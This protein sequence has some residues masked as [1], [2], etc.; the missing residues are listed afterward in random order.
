MSPVEDKL[1][2]AFQEKAGDIPACAPPLRLPARPRRS[3]FLAHGGGEKKGMPGYRAWHRWTAPVASA[4]LVVAV[5][6][7]SAVV[8]RDGSSAVFRHG[9]PSSPAHATATRPLLVAR[10]SSYLGVYLGMSPTG[11]PS[12]Q[13]A[14]SFAAAARTGPNLVE[15]VSNWGQPFA[16]SYAQTLRK[17]GA[18]MVVQLDPTDASLA[19]IPAGRY[20]GYLSSYAESVRD[21]GHPVII[22]FAHEMNADWWSWGYMHSRPSAAVA[23]W[24]HIVNLFR[25]LGVDNVTW[26]W[27]INADS[28]GTAAPAAWWPGSGYVTWVGIDGYYTQPADHFA[29][30]FGPAIAQVRELTA[31]PILLSQTAAASEA[32]QYADIS[33]LFEGMSAY[34]LLGLVWSETTSD[35]GVDWRLQG[36]RAEAAF[37][38]GAAGMTLARP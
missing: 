13:A 30:I 35:A 9:S 29:D 5:I 11:P 7:A 24:R 32:G 31:K 21:F 4:V 16:A 25:A 12:Y 20:D 26:L 8:F 2:A 22:G 37:R 15:Y 6:A 18:I 34:G 33:N 28:P 14:Q 23:A 27:T 10:P 19:S 38:A 3:P 17:H 1:R 36:R